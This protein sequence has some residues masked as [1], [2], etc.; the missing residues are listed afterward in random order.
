MLLLTPVLKPPTYQ[1][2]SN[3]RGNYHPIVD[4]N[5]ISSSHAHSTRHVQLLQAG[6]VSSSEPRGPALL[7]IARLWPPSMSL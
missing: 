3:H 7:Y 1:P 2:F 4:A 5:L 6:G